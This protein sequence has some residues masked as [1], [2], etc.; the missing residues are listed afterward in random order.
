MGEVERPGPASEE[1]RP[2]RRRKLERVY[3]A[4]SARDTDSIAAELGEGFEFHAVTGRRV[5]R[6][7]PYRWPEGLEQY[8]ADVE[9]VWEELRL[10]PQRFYERGDTVLVI[11]RVWGRT[12]AQLTDSPVAWL[13]RFDGDELVEGRAFERRDQGVELFEAADAQFSPGAYG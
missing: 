6:S 9:R 10:T 5:G 7:E 13:W 2:E 1:V 3:R 12:K 11:G 4:F 8:F